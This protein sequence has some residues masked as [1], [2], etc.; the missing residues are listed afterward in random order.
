MNRF[1]NYTTDEDGG[2]ELR[3]ESE[4]ASETWWGDEVT[5]KAFREELAAHPGD[6]TVWINSP[7]GDVVAASCIYTALKNHAGKVT[8][9][10]DG[11]AAS[12]ASVVAMA[13]DEVLISPTGYMMIH[14]P[15]TIAMGNS[16]DMRAA[17]KMLDEVAGGILTAYEQKTGQSRDKLERLMDAE[18]WMNAETA[19]DLGFAD[20][21]L[22]ADGKNDG[23]PDAFAPI[24]AEGASNLLGNPARPRKMVA[25][26]AASAGR[27][28]MQRVLDDAK[29]AQAA[30][31]EEDRRK[32]LALRLKFLAQKQ[33][34]ERKGV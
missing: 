16:D 20:G 1:W 4:I 7:G 23:E 21:M 27:L 29:K 15:A 8:V 12:A 34:N 26:A 22:F 25:Y 2:N 10:I 11:L 28:L 17:A 13:G 30:H 31:D 24:G 14:N 18:T 19:V 33:A 6:L 9:K 32:R 3:L 5:P